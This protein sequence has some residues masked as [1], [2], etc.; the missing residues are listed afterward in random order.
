M[1]ADNAKAS[2]HLLIMHQL[3]NIFQNMILAVT[4]QN[5]QAQAAL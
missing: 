2:K 3:L 4:K 1:Q 5:W